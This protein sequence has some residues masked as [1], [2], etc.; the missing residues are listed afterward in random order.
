MTPEFNNGWGTWANYVLKE[1]ERQDEEDKST[2][3]CLTEMKIDMATLK[4][5]SGL[6]GAAGS[7]IPVLILILIQLYLK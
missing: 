2:K 6:W 7:A 1:L 5:R 4:V 3:A